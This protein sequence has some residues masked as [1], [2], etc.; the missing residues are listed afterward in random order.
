MA[1]ER[2]I[3][4]FLKSFPKGQNSD[5]DPLLLPPDQLSFASNA[6]VRGDFASQR[7]PFLNLQLSYDEAQTGTDFQTGL[8]QGACY[9]RNGSNGYI[10]L[11][12]SGKLFRITINPGGTALVAEITIPSLNSA[13]AVQ[14]WLW[15]S[16]G[17]VIW[18][19]G[20][21]LPIFYDGTNTRRSLGAYP[22]Q[23]G[24]LAVGFTVP[25]LNQYVAG[26]VSLNAAWTGGL[27]MILIGSALYNVQSYTGASVGG[28]VTLGLNA[29]TYAGG[30]LINPGSAVS[31]NNKYLGTIL[32]AT[33]DSGNSITAFPAQP[34]G[35]TD[36]NALTLTVL[37]DTAAGLASTV[38]LGTTIN[39]SAY[40]AGTIVS[41]TQGGIVI[42]QWPSKDGPTLTIIGSGYGNVK[43]GGEAKIKPG[44][45][46]G[47][48]F[49]NGF[50]IS[51]DNNIT[52]TMSISSLGDTQSVGGPVP[53]GGYF[54][55][56]T[57]QQGDVITSKS[58][59]V[60]P[61]I[62]IPSFVLNLS[63]NFA[64][65][66]GDILQVGTATMQVDSISDAS[67]TCHMTSSSAGGT[68][69]DAGLVLNNNKSGAAPTGYGT[70]ILNAPAIP[71]VGG[72][73]TLD[74]T[75]GAT[76]SE[77]QILYF[78]T[79]HA[80]GTGTVAAL[81][82]DVTN[83]TIGAAGNYFRITLSIPFAGHVGDSLKIGVGNTLA[84]FTVTAIENASVIQCQMT[85]VP[86]VTTIPI[87]SATPT[88]SQIV[89]NNSASGALIGVGTYPLTDGA[90]PPISLNPK[91]VNA[92]FTITTLPSQTQ[93]AIGQ[94]VQI[95]T[96]I[97]T[98]D[99]FQVYSVSGGSTGSTPTI[100]IQNINDTEGNQVAAGTYIYSIPELPISKMGCYGMGRNWVALPD[101]VSYVASDLVGSSTGTQAYN[102]TDS[103]LKVSQN[104]FLAG[105][106]T[107]AIS[108]SGEQI[109]AMA[110]SASLDVSLGTGPLQVFTDNTVF[111]NVAPSDMTEWSTLTSPIQIE[112]LIGSGAISQEDV[113][114]SNGDLLF[115]LSD[116]GIQSMLMA[117]L[118]FNKWGNTPI[119]KEVS[120]SIRNDDS[121]LIPFS[122]GV[123][124]N[125]R[126]LSTCQP[127][128]ASRGVIWKSMVAL[129]FDPISSLSGKAPSVWEG[130]WTGLNVLHLITGFFN[131]EKQCY[132]IC[133]SADLT[134]IELHQIQLDG[135][136]YL[137]N[138]LQPI[139]WFFESPMIYRENM[140]SKRDYKRLVNGEFSVKDIVADVA[141]QVFYRS[142][143]NPNWTPWY[144]S[145]IVYQGVNDPG[146]RRR[147][148]IGMPDPKV[149]D[150]T[151]NQPMR[152][153]YNFQVKFQFS[154][155][156]TLTDARIAAII[157][158]EPEFGR[159]T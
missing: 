60:W 124:F 56:N 158:P 57:I 85:N 77:G 146:Y 149:F 3:Y 64:G 55:C 74:T 152:E 84:T 122:K 102:F 65:S 148:P 117:R 15:Q 18:N 62:G 92:S 41:A 87:T 23:L 154:G 78:T 143:Q 153:G 96:S 126:R 83:G 31:I 48:A 91:A 109:H 123:V 115:R 139:S 46:G 42:K 99:L 130:E 118:D 136:G 14:N 17:F 27:G 26:D 10:M 86:V 81:V 128:Q 54:Y 110:F 32:D 132:A 114:L 6:T 93:A 36:G 20:L 82:T 13:A 37:S 40:Y 79:T 135:S 120:R 1:G 9:Y 5:V 150:A 51:T 103:V 159:V 34:V 35:G 134:Q 98:V 112:G 63:T 8:F 30:D 76:V 4:G 49:V 119:S 137:D 105:G 155:K 38:A 94:I 25:A 53:A 72:S 104:Y 157:I 140:E 67:V 2:L 125:N 58:L 151:N 12:V 156:C 21:N 33:D 68:I 52:I 113:T 50:V 39:G 16:E 47:N 121:T 69:P 145:T 116:G 97:G 144:S 131:G 111:S 101:G 66:V 70:S 73:I 88:A 107:F 108:G 75:S 43:V 133:L 129:Q 141:Y 7:P 95:T 127:V 147:I 59:S 22:V 106:G 24:S 71:A 19:D 28:R 142:D 90:T 29:I 11:A 61:T 89:I 45:Y 44:P 80:G 100:R 138:G